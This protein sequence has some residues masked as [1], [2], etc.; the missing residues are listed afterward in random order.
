M[1]VEDEP[2]QTVAGDK[3]K[4]DVGALVTVIVLVV[5]DEQVPLVTVS[6]TVLVPVVDQAT[7]CGPAVDAVAGV[8]PDPKFQEYVEPAGAVPV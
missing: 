3:V 1:I 5:V 2:T 4:V 7:D 6:V 8:A